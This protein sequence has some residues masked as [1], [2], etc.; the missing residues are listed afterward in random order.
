MASFSSGRD[1]AIVVVV[2]D[3]PFYLAISPF[4]SCRNYCDSWFRQVFWLFV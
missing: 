1:S 4:L 3:L 2:L